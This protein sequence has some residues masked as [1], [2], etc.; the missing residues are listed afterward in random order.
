MTSGEH[1][2]GA[3]SAATPPSSFGGAGASFDE[4][5]EHD[6]AAPARDAAARM[7]KSADVDQR[8]TRG[9]FFIAA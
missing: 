6:A 7:A 4:K 3:V 1:A 5:L 8:V 9:Y 2:E